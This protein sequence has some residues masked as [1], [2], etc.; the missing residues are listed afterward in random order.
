MASANL[1]Q[2][3]HRRVV[4]AMPEP[5]AVVDCALRI[6]MANRAFGRICDLGETQM[7]GSPVFGGVLTV[8]AQERLQTLLHEAAVDERTF[9][10]VPI[11]VLL[12]S[13]RRSLILSTRPIEDGP[14]C[15]GAAEPLML[16]TFRDNHWARSTSATTSVDAS[17]KQLVEINHRVKN[18]LGAILAMLRLEGRD[19]HDP[20]TREV[21]HRIAMRVQAIASLY[22][23]LSLERRAGVV[24]LLR[25]LRT[26]ARSIEQVAGG[27]RGGWTIDVAGTD[28][29]V[30]I[31]DAARYGAI[32]NELVSNAAKYAF[33]DGTSGGIVRI[34]CERVG[35]TVEVEVADNGSGIAVAGT[36]PPSTGLGIRLVDLYL[37]ALDGE[38]QRSTAPGRGT[39]CTLRMPYRPVA[40]PAPEP[41]DPPARLIASRSLPFDTPAAAGT[42]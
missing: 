7:L 37:H 36:A 40:E 31:D 16:L 13:G 34:R 42:S 18:N 5:M 20:G 4:D 25:Y 28:F 6:R 3:L 17:N 32:V 38:M 33:A 11:E 29:D 10:R 12:P 15:N 8:F 9:D 41:A 35:D 19:A 27:G 22:E 2:N 14:P 26:I 23:V 30:S 21:L 1:M 24:G 39:V